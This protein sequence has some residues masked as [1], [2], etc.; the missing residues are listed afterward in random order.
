MDNQ[1]A[2]EIARDR[3]ESISKFITTNESE[4]KAAEETLE[5]LKFV[6]KLLEA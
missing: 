3:I 1:K 4:K 6:E 2:L 5:F